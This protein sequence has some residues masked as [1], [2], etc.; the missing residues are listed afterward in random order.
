MRV[1]TCLLLEVGIYVRYI[2]TFRGKHRVVWL[3]KITINLIYTNLKKN[4]CS[5]DC[6][7]LLQLRSRY[8]STNHSGVFENGSYS[9]YI[10]I[11]ITAFSLSF[12]ILFN[13]N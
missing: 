5:T 9:C 7:K 4:T 6:N 2:P 8:R 11:L 10:R 12:G 13:F 3:F 1:L